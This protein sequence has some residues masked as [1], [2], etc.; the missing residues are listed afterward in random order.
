VGKPFTYDELAERIR[1]VVRRRDGRR[2]GPLRVGE[3]FIVFP[4]DRLEEGPRHWRARMTVA[5]GTA[6]P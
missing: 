5:G 2:H 3:I 6:G 1:S 4:E